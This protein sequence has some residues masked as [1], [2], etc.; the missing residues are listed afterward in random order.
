VDADASTVVRTRPPAPP[1]ILREES[2][3]PPLDFS[4]TAVAFKSKSTAD[5]VR[6]LLVFRVCTMKRLVQNSDRLM[7]AAKRVLGDR[8]VAAAFRPTFFRHFCAGEDEAGIRPTV[9]H[10]NRF[11]VGGILDYAAEADLEE[12][13]GEGGGGA[14]NLDWPEDGSN[15]PGAA[16][17][18]RTYCYTS[19][20]SCDANAAI[21]ET[22]IRAVANVSPEGFAA[23]KITALG[24]PKLLERVSQTITA[25]RD[26]FHRYDR[27]GDGLLSRDEFVEAFRADF[28]ISEEEIQSRFD[29]FK[30]RCA[31]DGDAS[32]P[33]R[34]PADA[35]DA[36]DF[37]EWTKSLPL[38]DLWA[39]AKRCRTKGPL[40]DSVLGEEESDLLRALVARTDRLCALAAAEGVRVMID[41]EQTYFQPAIDHVVLEMQRRYNKP[42][43][44]LVKDRAVVYNTYQMYLKDA[45]ARLE[46][47]LERS[48]RE[49]WQFACKTVR[50]AYMVAERARAKELGQESPVHETLE[51]THNGYDA[52]VEMLLTREEVL[53]GAQPANVLVASHNQR[54]VERAIRV[55][56]RSG[57]EPGG[58]GVYFGQLLGM[59]DHLSFVLGQNG[60]KAYKYVPF[61]P[62]HEVLPYLV[63]RAQENSDIMQGVGTEMKMLRAELK[64]RWL[65][66][67]G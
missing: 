21:F 26:L 55:M 34:R 64:R 52:A 32:P 38:T 15:P 49:G 47:D 33:A 19:E 9:E 4:D 41:A 37:V 45:R 57:L 3:H 17:V 7:A 51:D 54:S 53:S 58:R 65:P 5:I 18:A 20:R 39:L 22:C 59:S 62:V 28:D 63:R 23:L 50:G 36:L 8:V 16:T 11:G 10:I 29:A 25:V 14:I 61:G 35:T 31:G 66:G 12:S 43:P 56:E 6:A 13:G 46:L 60:Y 44:N 30:S 48:R 40:A 24:N 42:G 1:T 27:D 67:R 2:A